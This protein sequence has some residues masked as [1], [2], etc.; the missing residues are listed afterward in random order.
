MKRGSRPALAQRFLRWAAG[1]LAALAM[2]SAASAG[3]PI[4]GRAQDLRFSLEELIHETSADY[5]AY[6]ERLEA[7]QRIERE[8]ANSRRVERIFRQLLPQAMRLHARNASIRWQVFVLR[9]GSANF[10]LPDGTLFVAADWAKRGRL[11][12]PELALLIA[13]EMAHVICD[14]MLERVSALAANQ[15]G[16]SRIRDLLRQSREQWH[17]LGE[18]APLMRTQ[19]MEADRVGAAILGASGLPLAEAVGLFD[20]MARA[21]RR[22]IGMAFV[23]S[24]DTALQRK[25]GLLEW[26]FSMDWPG[27]SAGRNDGG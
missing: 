21:E 15:P 4:T 27:G 24:H 7:K 17:A 12:D 26:A 2:M 11:S 23:N 22:A 13:H 16:R 10:A 3:T 8:T 20:H 19:E 9:Q 1:G 25:A 5:Q 18:I 14:H 6:L